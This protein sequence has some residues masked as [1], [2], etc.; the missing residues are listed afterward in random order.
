MKM[1]VKI[2]CKVPSIPSAR[3]VVSHGSSDAGV[4]GV[5]AF[6]SAF[7]AFEI[8]TVVASLRLS[9]AEARELAARLLAEADKAV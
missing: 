9:P 4:H 3:V 6:I 1:F 5:T 8:P 7:D 2:H